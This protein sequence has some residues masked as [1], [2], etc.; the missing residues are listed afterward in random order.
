MA[1][2][3]AKTS[4][5]IAVDDEL[6]TLLNWTNIES[7]S[8]FTVIVENADAGGDDIV[9]VQLD[10]SDDGGITPVLDAH[11]GVPAVPIEAGDA[12]KG[13]FTETAK[14]VRIRAICDTGKDTTAVAYLMADSSVGRI[15][16][17]A[18]VRDRLGI[19]DAQYDETINRIIVS[20]AD[21]FD[22]YTNRN[23]LV[24]TLPVTE[25]YMASG[26]WLRVKR[27]PIVAVTTIKESYT[28]DFDN[29]VALTA[30]TDYRLVDNGDKGLIYRLYGIW[31]FLP[32]SVQIVYRGGFVA[33]GQTPGEGE[34]ALPNDLREAAIQQASFIFK[35]R[36][37]I[38]L[39]SQSSEGGS[40]SSFSAMDLL[41]LVKQTL[42]NYKRLIL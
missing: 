41:P 35:R 27:Y 30:D 38:G 7:L 36:L 26:P 28:F 25:Y 32:D 8:G 40:I 11:A 34:M 17:L 15:C 10:T 14:F 20:L 2:L 21:L 4:V 42:D 29:T 16:T 18:D 23:L 1:E 19:S 22:R 3:I 39:L 5:A 12:K 33:A 13:A 37:D 9:D 6:T 31:P 24:N